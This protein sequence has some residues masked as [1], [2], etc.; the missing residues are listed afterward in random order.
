MAA[1]WDSDRVQRVFALATVAMTD[2]GGA[3]RAAGRKVSSCRATIGHHLGLLSLLTS[4]V[5]VGLW[6]QFSA[7]ASTDYPARSD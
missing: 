4:G 6:P 1:T 5:W 7:A 3:F 2:R